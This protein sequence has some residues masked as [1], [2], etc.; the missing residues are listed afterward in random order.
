[1]NTKKYRIVIKIG[2]SSL[3][4]QHGFLS[5]KKLEHHVKEIVKLLK[6]GHEVVLVSS[7]AV[8][9]GFHLLGFEERPE[10]IEGKQAAAAIGQGL[11]IQAYS[12]A[13]QKYHYTVAQ[14]LL[15]RNDFSNQKQYYYAYR[16]LSMLIKHSIIP[17]INEN[18]TV[19][20]DELTFGDNDQLSA[21]VAGLIHADLLLLL[22]DIDGLYYSDPR[23]NPNAKKIT[24]LEEITSQI[25]NIASENGSKF[26]TGGM[27]S[28][29]YAAKLALSFGVNVYIGKAITNCSFLDIIQGHGEGT[30]IGRS[31]FCPTS[32]NC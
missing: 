11:L 2:S 23:S 10:T 31:L 28:K 13:F 17:V 19:A 1:M 22:T 21:L 12:E 9:A 16:T 25:E 27:K 3:T 26:G 7:G 18:D 6:A 14:I 8:A 5:H 29:I 20:I 24:Y 15:T 30:Y 4:D 32:K